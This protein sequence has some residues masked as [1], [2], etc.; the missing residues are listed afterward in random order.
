MKKK[1]VHRYPFFY[2]VPVHRSGSYFIGTDLTIP[3]QD[4]IQ[5]EYFLCPAYWLC[6][7]RSR[8]L[9][10]NVGDLPTHFVGKEEDSLC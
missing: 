3:N 4:D 5:V 9:R 8:A 2:V 1:T 10:A 7:Y 6:I